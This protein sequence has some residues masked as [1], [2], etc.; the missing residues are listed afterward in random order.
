[1]TSHAV[2]L[3]DGGGDLALIAKIKIKNIFKMVTLIMFVLYFFIKVEI[4]LLNNVNLTDRFTSTLI[5][6]LFIF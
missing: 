1:M 2:V 4:T 3:Q 5:L 6:N